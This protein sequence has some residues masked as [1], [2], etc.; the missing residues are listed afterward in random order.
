MMMRRA[1]LKQKL[2][3]YLLGFITLLLVMLWLFQ[4]VFLDSFYQQVK[5]LEIRNAA[6]VIA[7]NIGKSHLSSLITEKSDNGEIY[8]EVCNSSGKTL[9]T[10]SNTKYK[11]SLLDKQ[12]ILAR[13]KSNGGSYYKKLALAPPE[14][15]KGSLVLNEKNPQK[16]AS[17]LQQSNNGSEQQMLAYIK[18][19]SYDGKEYAVIFNAVIS[20]VN[21]TVTTLRYQLYFIT[22]I[23]ILLSVLL[24]F[25]ISKRIAKPI[26][27]ISKEAKLLAEG[28]YDTRFNGKGYVE[29]EELSNI[30]NTA[31][32]ELDKV[33]ALRREL[34]AN[35]SHDLRTPLALIYSYAEMMN[36]F[37]GE[38]TPEQTQ[39][40]MV[41]AQRLTTLVNDVLDI[42]KLESGTQELKKNEYD[43]TKSVKENIDRLADLVQK[44]GYHLSFEYDREISI[45]ADE[46]RITQV[47]YNLLFNA[48]HYSGQDK[49]IRIKQITNNTEVRLEV[50]DTG[51]GI[52]PEN[53][54]YIWDRYYKVDKRHK[55]ST[56]GSGLGLSIVK[57]VIQLH[58]GEYGVIS[59]VGEGSTFWFSLKL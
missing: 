9:V 50:I 40:I 27:D 14:I 54:P 29:I 19:A 35:V 31:A 6:K 28:R 45:Y 11:V 10:S 8:I 7:S 36:D 1:T 2:F 57:K 5:V 21:A 4:T 44:D 47:L 56:M 20:P 12:E 38:I 52:E 30:L 32:T 23:M 39:V 49:G 15:P 3:A 58:G 51:I 17:K 41:E 37:P 43:F 34:L 59:K 13:A 24:A 46:V 26:E 18:L 25:A 22:V 16:D 55:R 53:L 33:E 48:I 42:S